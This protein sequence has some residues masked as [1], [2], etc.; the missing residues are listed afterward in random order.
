MDAK[1]KRHSRRF[2]GSVLFTVLVV[3]VVM[4][5]LMIT[6][7]GLAGASSRRAYSEYFD[8]QTTSTGRSVINS[9]VES[10]KTTNQ[11][12]G[13]SIV[14]E[15]QNG[16]KGKQVEVTVN[17]GAN[18]G[19]GFGTVDHLY[20]T[21]VGKD[22]ASDINITG[23]GQ[24]IIKVTAVVTQGGT[25]S[26]YSQYCMGAVDSNNQV[27]SG[28][29]LIALGGFEGV[30]EPGVDAHSPAYFGV[31]NTFTYDKLVTLS[32]PNSAEFNELIV[33]SSAEV[34]TQLKYALARKEGLSVMGSL[35]VND[36]T[37]K[38]FSIDGHTAAQFKDE[39][40]A[41]GVQPTD[42]N[43]VYVGG[44]LYLKN[45]LEVG[46][47]EAPMNVYCGRFVTEHNGNIVGNCD[48]FCYN[49]GSTAASYDQTNLE[50]FSKNP[51]SKFGTANQ[52]KLIS[53]AEQV[54]D[55]A[56]RKT[57]NDSG[58]FYTMGNLELTGKA[59]IE[60]DLYVKGDVNVHDLTNGEAAIKGNAYVGGSIND[61]AALR[62]IVAGELYYGAADN[63]AD[64]TKAY[65]SS[66]LPAKVNDFLSGTLTKTSLT[67]NIVKTPE[68]LYNSFYVDEKDINGNPTG[69]KI[70]KD[71]VNKSLLN[72]NSNTKV[73]FSPNNG[74]IQ[75]RTINESTGHAVT[76]GSVEGYNYDVEITESCIM[77]GNFGGLN[78]YINP[79]SEIWI[80]C[81]NLQ[82]SNNSKIIIN[83]SDGTVKVNFFFPTSVSQS[84]V[85]TDCQSA[86]SSLITNYTYTD[87]PGG[88]ATTHSYANVFKTDSETQIQTLAY[89]KNWKAGNTI[90]LVTYPTADSDP[91]NNWM[92]PKVGFYAA[93]DS[94]GTAPVV[95]V[96]FTNNVFVTG[97]IVMPSADFTAKSG[98]ASANG[99]INYNGRAVTSGK[100][101]C[102][103]SII[104]NKIKE[105]NNDFGMIYVDDPAVLPPGGTGGGTYAWA[106]IDGYA[107]F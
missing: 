22:D 77:T 71:S 53:W 14:S 39:V 60:G 65:S 83:D 58:S 47:N 46:N 100:V 67:T 64:N 50:N 61:V 75:Y 73:Y 68:K 98:C 80:D 28:G 57:I 51:W 18:L 26:T 85:A 93:E 79:T 20:F 86:Y 23:S 103:G 27:S 9:V 76:G 88:V 19:E 59:S 92:L 56:H 15:I 6:A 54:S 90:N 45:N 78:I 87:Y 30:S 43:Y 41:G 29:G 104:V 36:G 105:F 99:I 3:M 33:N 2:K 89:Y 63:T 31:K 13:N 49:E 10:F 84:N 81:F 8:H 42:N 95:G 25:T 40:N 11:G 35:F 107:D 55:T 66:A 48:I 74:Q 38:I 94:T 12:M 34:K 62:G 101:G 69:R 97:D 102:V 52:T 82:L 16:P 17:G 32:N 44:T 7:I 106:S 4:V 1:T 37:T 91:S 96:V 24:A 21:Y 70:Y 5:I 72:V